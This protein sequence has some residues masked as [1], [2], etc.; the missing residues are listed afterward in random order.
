MMMEGPNREEGLARLGHLLATPGAEREAE[1]VP[2]PA[3]PRYNAEGECF[4]PVHGRGQ[5]PRAWDKV[6]VPEDSE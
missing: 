6:F 1:P 4:T 2:S 5:R 3:R